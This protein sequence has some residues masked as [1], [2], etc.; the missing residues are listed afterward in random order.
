[1]K[2]LYLFANVSYLH[3]KML[4]DEAKR[5]ERRAGDKQ[6]KVISLT[7]ILCFALFY[8]NACKQQIN[9]IIKLL[10]DKNVIKRVLIFSEHREICIRKVCSTSTTFCV[11]Q[12]NIT[13]SVE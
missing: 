3:L 10:R 2:F 12:Q 4:E 9:C 5:R 11:L 13:K 1:M 8:V 6:D 7:T